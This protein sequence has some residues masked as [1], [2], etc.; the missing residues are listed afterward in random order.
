[1]DD[2]K[3]PGWLGRLT[4]RLHSLI[5]PR[6]EGRR[7]TVPSQKAMLSL[8]GRD[9]AVSILDLSQSG[10]MITFGGHAYE[11]D[12]VTIQLLDHGLVAGQVRWIRDGRAGISFNRPLKGESKGA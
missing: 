10:A 4:H 9:H 7:A 8:R 3:E 1:M 12:P 11:G 2:T 6:R 5:D